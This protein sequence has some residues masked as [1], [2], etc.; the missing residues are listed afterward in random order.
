[1]NTYIRFFVLFLLIMTLPRLANAAMPVEIIQTT[2]DTVGQRLVYY[3]KEGIRASN[4]MTLAFDEKTP[5]MQV[6]IVTIDQNPANPGYS[7][8][9]S[10]VVLWENPNQPFPF[11]LNQYVGYCG[12]NRVRACADDLVANISQNSDE[13]IKLL[14]NASK[15]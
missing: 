12:A 13:I 9:Y 14:I 8:A 5:R 11:Y 10:F 6:E 15:N 7:T 4:S 3:V 2:G 1:M